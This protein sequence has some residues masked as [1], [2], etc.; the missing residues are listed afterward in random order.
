METKQIS[1]KLH[2][3]DYNHIKKAAIL[4]KRSLSNFLKFA[5]DRRADEVLNNQQQ[6]K[7]VLESESS[8]QH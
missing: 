7:E 4:D 1:V 6:E 3:S 5:A 2:Q 8:I